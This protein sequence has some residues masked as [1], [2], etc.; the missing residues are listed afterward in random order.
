[1]SAPATARSVHASLELIDSPGPVPC[2]GR[3]S[4][5]SVDTHDLVR[6]V[7]YELPKRP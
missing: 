1:M 7:A 6:L 5:E 2:G 4:V 3:S